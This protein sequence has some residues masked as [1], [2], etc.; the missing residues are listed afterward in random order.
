MAG[1]HQQNC[2]TWLCGARVLTETELLVLLWPLAGDCLEVEGESLWNKT[3]G[4]LTQN[5]STETD[6]YINIYNHSLTTI[7]FEV[8]AIK[9]AILT[10]LH[11]FAEV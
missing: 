4:S 9:G 3:Q 7:S 5:T 1:E 10:Y 8:N 2:H 11:D 6:I